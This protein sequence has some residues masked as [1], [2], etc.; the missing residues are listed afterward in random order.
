MYHIIDPSRE[1]ARTTVL[2][3]A[4]NPRSQLFGQREGISTPKT[5]WYKTS[6]ETVQDYHIPFLL[7]LHTDHQ[8]GSRDKTGRRKEDM[9]REAKVEKLSRV[10]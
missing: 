4:S 9:R 3:K 2:T 5:G 8:L 6:R 1:T 7:G 10:N